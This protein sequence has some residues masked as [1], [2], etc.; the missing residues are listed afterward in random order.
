[1]GGLDQVKL[2]NYCRN[3]DESESYILR[4][5]QVNRA[6][7]LLTPYAHSVRL[8]RVT[9]VDSASGKKE[10][11]RYAMLQEEPT[12]LAG[13]LNGKIM[14]ATGAVAD[15]LDPMQSGI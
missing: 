9:Y 13:R 5:L 4:E 12:A 14:K 15:D 8:A 1:F 7:R 10:T 3:N 2:A 11:T 6:L